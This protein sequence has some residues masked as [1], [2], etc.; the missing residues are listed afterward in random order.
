MAVKLLEKEP[1]TFD[2]FASV[3]RCVVREKDGTLVGYFS[4]I[5]CAARSVVERPESYCI[6]ELG[7]Q[8]SMADCI[9]YLRSIRVLK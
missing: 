9:Q 5:G 7:K 6:D 3:H 1:I 4:N 8:W 2:Q